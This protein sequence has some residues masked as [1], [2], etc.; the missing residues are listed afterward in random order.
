MSAGIP[1]IFVDDSDPSIIYS[2]KDAWVPVTKIS[3]IP[4]PFVLPAR[5]PFYGTTHQITGNATLSYI[6]NGTYITA[7]LFTNRN[8][9]ISIACLFDGEEQAT[10]LDQADNL[11]CPN[12]PTKP[13]ADGQHNL[14]ISFTQPTEGFGITLLPYFDGLVYTPSNK[15]YMAQVQNTDVTYNLQRAL[16]AG[17]NFTSGKTPSVSSPNLFPGDSFDFDFK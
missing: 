1:D 4:Q 13:P 5:G 9:A 15:S 3:T 16:L 7:F 11:Y 12:N 17:M 14:T 6:Y 2:G 8:A 10:V